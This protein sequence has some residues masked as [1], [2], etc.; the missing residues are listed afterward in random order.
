MAEPTATF[1]PEDVGEWMTLEELVRAGV[2]PRAMLS[3][4]PRVGD[5]ALR[6]KLRVTE[7]RVSPDSSLTLVLSGRPEEEV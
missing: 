4:L 2:M 6:A 3:S 1:R 5:W 7:V